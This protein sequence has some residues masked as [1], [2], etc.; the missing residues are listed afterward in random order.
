MTKKEYEAA[1]A[2]ESEIPTWAETEADR[3]AA[4]AATPK[5]IKGYK[6]VAGAEFGIGIDDGMFQD[7]YDENFIVVPIYDE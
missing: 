1:L 4:E 2:A 7:S 3:E 5:I 6:K